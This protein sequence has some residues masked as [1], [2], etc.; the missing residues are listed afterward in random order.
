VLHIGAML[1]ELEKLEPPKEVIVM[2]PDN[3]TITSDDRPETTE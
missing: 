2:T 3:Y 1:D